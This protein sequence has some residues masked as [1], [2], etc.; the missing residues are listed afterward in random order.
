MAI[1]R[2]SL[3]RKDLRLAGRTR[4]ALSRLIPRVYVDCGKREAGVFLRLTH[5]DQPAA[6]Y[7][8][9]R[10]SSTTRKVSEVLQAR[11]TLAHG[12]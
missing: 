3:W 4:L 9:T 2:K 11:Y 6:R 1:C 12:K 8:L 5:G 10:Y 7:T